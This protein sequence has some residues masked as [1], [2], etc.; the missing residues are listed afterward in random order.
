MEQGESPL[1]VIFDRFAKDRDFSEFMGQI[2]KK[3]RDEYQVAGTIL[4]QL[5]AELSSVEQL[6]DDM[7]NLAFK[8]P[9]EIG[10]GEEY[11]IDGIT[12]SQAAAILGFYDEA[13]GDAKRSRGR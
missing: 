13:G 6:P 4:A 12:K 10:E 9:G 3:E 2:R 1:K 11:R 8:I 5:G 7:F